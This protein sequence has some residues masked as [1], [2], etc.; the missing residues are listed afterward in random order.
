MFPPPSHYVPGSYLHESGE[1]RSLRSMAS[2]A[3]EEL[4]SDYWT[5]ASMAICPSDSRADGGEGWWIWSD[6]GGNGVKRNFAAQIED[7]ASRDD[8]LPSSWGTP[9]PRGKELC[10][11]TYLSW[12]VS[13]CYA[14]YG[15]TSWS[16]VVDVMGARRRYW[17]WMYSD[18]ANNLPD[19]KLMAWY[20]NDY[21]AQFGC[22]SWEIVEYD[23]RPVQEDMNLDGMLQWS[24][25]RMSPEGWN[26]VNGMKDDDGSNLPNR[27]LHLRE[28]MERFFI[29]DINNPADGAQAQ[30]N[31][32]V[33]W[34]AFTSPMDNEWTGPGDSPVMRFNHVPGGS[35]VLYMDG[36]VEFLKYGSNKLTLADFPGLRGKDGNRL[37]A[38]YRSYFS[39]MGGWG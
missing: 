12:P 33:M 28:G 9:Y 6:A 19:W 14:G 23:L 15:V 32:I 16:Q 17:D 22:K 30:S 36:H 3:G 5:D 27:Y 24:D 4:Y 31:I 39:I 7:I 18:P 38:Q 29:V 35:N 26:P 8:D 1:Y 10:L 2:F 21:F 20:G 37:C 25:W 13:Y 11:N 34:D